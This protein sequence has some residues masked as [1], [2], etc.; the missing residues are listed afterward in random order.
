[1]NDDW[2]LKWLKCYNY[3][4]F[5]VSQECM[6]SLFAMVAS[7]WM[8]FWEYKTYFQF[9]SVAERTDVVVNSIG[10]YIWGSE[11]ELT[12]A[13]SENFESWYLLCL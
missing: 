7:F 13:F 9:L 8:V 12:V 5:G 11:D 1:M 10:E 6:S 4:F 2:V 3:V